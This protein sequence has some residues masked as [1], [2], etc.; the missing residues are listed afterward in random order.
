MERIQAYQLR[1]V[2]GRENGA[3]QRHRGAGV[4]HDPSLNLAGAKA[5]GARS[6]GWYP[7]GLWRHNSSSSVLDRGWDGDDGADPAA[8]SRWNLITPADA[9]SPSLQFVPYSLSRRA[10]ASE[11]S[12]G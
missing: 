10:P 1:R 6:G 4:S 5:A 2:G 7:A 8:R 12:G 11:A 3:I 9:G